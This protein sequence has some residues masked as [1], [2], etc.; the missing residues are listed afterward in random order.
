VPTSLATHPRPTSGAP[1]ARAAKLNPRFAALLLA[2][3]L[4]L[5]G[6]LPAD[7]RPSPSASAS[8]APPTASLSP[9]PAATAAAPTPTPGPTFLV[10]TVVRGDSLISLA[11]RYETT[12][13][14]IA[15]WNRDTYPSLDPDSAAYDPDRVEIGWQ[16]R[17]LPGEVF[18]PPEPTGEPSPTPQASLVIPAGP[19]PNPSGPAVVVSNGGRGGNAV[20]LTFDLGGR[21]E[22]AADV[23]IWL[24]E[25][26]VPATIF[27]TGEAATSGTAGQA[28]LALVAAH[29]D[30]LTVGNHSWDY[31]DFT[32][33]SAAAI[34]DQ[35][36]RSE[37]AIESAVGRSTRPFLRP[38][39]GA[40]SS[41][42]RDAVGAA[43]WA[44]VVMWD[45][46][47]TD[48]RPESDGGPTTDE[49]RSKVLSRAQGGSIVAMN[50]GG[51]HTL[52]ALPG[53]VEGLRA[54]GLEPVTLHRLL[55]V[56][57]GG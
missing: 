15:Y 23:A 49:I 27:P 17:L 5:A 10:H 25:H 47:A 52:E 8:T 55:G 30:L 13:R 34:R 29:P 3:A 2:A 9:T 14:S 31:A 48:W 40:H 1:E 46:D 20:A 57:P 51:D 42:T 12:A 7:V 22:P 6:C 28:V 33:L 32:T 41:A 43:G 36:T 19:T 21:V 54:R 39:Y 16:L 26:D 35:L 50:L 37:A 53:I 44:Y 24:V 4:I 11:R 45:V 56:E 18:E 38:P